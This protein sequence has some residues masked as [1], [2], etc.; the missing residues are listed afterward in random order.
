MIRR[1]VIRPALGAAY[2]CGPL[3]MLS[4]LSE[5]CVAAGLAVQVSLET[6]FGCGTGLCAG[7]AIPMKTGADD[8]FG[9]YAF[10]CTEGPIFDGTRVDWAGVRE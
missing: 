4:A 3:P 2:G 6:V 1:G 9:R 7:C 8:P 5:R 10:A